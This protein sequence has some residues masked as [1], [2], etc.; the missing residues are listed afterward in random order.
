MKSNAFE[1]N[2]KKIDKKIEERKKLSAGEF[3]DLMEDIIKLRS[4]N[5]VK[6]IAI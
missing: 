4:A 1:I 2:L 3:I 5:E 6:R